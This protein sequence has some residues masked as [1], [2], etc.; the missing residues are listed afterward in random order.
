MNLLLEYPPYHADTIQS[1]RGYKVSISSAIPYLDGMSSDTAVL[2][3]VRSPARCWG[4]YGRSGVTSIGL[5]PKIS[6]KLVD[7][8]SSERRDLCVRFWS[9]RLFLM[10][11][12]CFEV[13][14][15]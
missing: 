10:F 3:S 12:S 15:D 14:N 8:R 13:D 2:R 5:F 11:C 6:G 9:G 4:F 1:K 7:M